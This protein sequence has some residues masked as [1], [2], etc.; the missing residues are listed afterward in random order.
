MQTEV[1]SP[2]GV[3]QKRVKDHYKGHATFILHHVIPISE[4]GSVYDVDNL[5]VVTPAAHHD[6]HYGA[7]E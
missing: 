4:N 7:S 1:S 3:H 5:R 2:T 6:I